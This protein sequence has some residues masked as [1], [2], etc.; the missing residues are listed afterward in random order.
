MRKRIIKKVLFTIVTSQCA[1]SAY[2]VGPGLY[3][4]AMFGPATNDGSTQQAQVLNSPTTVPANPKSNQFA[5]RAFVGY[6]INRWAAFEAGLTYIPSVN[7]TTK[8]DVQTCGSTTMRV[9]DFELLGKG[10]VPFGNTFDVYGKAGVAYVYQSTG[11]ALN[12][13]LSEECGKTKYTSKF[14]PAVSVG[15]S[16]ALSQSWVTDISINRIMVSGI[17]KNIT[18]FQLGLSYH[19]VDRFCGQFLCDD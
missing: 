14:A 6:Q 8:G 5:S 2:A 18:T 3:M 19:F 7:F 1:M 12:P 17:L 15:A 16:Y 9:R 10:I 13:D 11:G 4:G